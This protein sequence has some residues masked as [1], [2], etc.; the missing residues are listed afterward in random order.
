MA[1]KHEGWIS[2][3][4]LGECSPY[5]YFHTGLKKIDISHLVQCAFA[6]VI[7]EPANKWPCD[8]YPHHIAPT[9][10][11]LSGNGGGSLGLCSISYQI[12]SSCSGILLTD[13]FWIRHLPKCL[14]SHLLH[15]CFLG[16]SQF[17][18]MEM[19]WVAIDHTY[20][21]L[22]TEIVCRHTYSTLIFH[23]MWVKR[24]C[25]QQERTAPRYS[26]HFNWHVWQVLKW[27]IRARKSRIW[28][29]QGTEKLLILRGIKTEKQFSRAMT[30]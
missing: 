14:E 15:G 6:L 30:A 18:I 20:R 10:G 1:H 2:K 5:P 9:G 3:W 29:G 28:R 13:I 27:G 25:Y 23:T 26:Q 11:F 22:S 8:F 21:R 12:Y 4:R 17:L 7:F 24:I 16:A 19:L